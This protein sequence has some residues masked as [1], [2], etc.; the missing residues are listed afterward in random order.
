MNKVIFGATAL[1][2]LAAC[3]QEPA[4]EAVTAAAAPLTSGINTEYMD[5]SVNPGDDFFTYVNGVWL[6]ETEIPADRSTFGG[7]SV[8]ADESQANVR[9]I[10][11]ESA[12][13]DFATGTDEQKVGDL[14]KSYLDWDSALMDKLE[15]DGTVSYKTA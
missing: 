9:A 12:S 5:K 14:Y 15:K 8:L 13:G 2:F 1:V 3:G 4:T 10:V 11:E 6:K 7:F